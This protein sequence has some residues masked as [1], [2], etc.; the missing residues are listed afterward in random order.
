MK[1]SCGMENVVLKLTITSS[2]ELSEEDDAVDDADGDE[3]GGKAEVAT[4]VATPVP[5]HVIDACLFL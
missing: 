1:D 2:S 5:W 3:A 4:D